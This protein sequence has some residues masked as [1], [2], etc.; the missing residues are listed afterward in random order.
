MPSDSFLDPQG[1]SVKTSFAGM[2]ET[3]DPRLLCV[4]RASFGGGVRVLWVAAGVSPADGQDGLQGRRPLLGSRARPHQGIRVNTEA[5]RK[6]S[7]DWRPSG[8]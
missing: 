4:L 2:V 1:H 6:G 7:A 5:V 8:R 3:L